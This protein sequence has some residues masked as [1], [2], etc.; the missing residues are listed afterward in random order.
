VTVFLTYRCN[1]DCPYRKTITR[2]AEDLRAFPQK[3]V[4]YDYDSFRELLLRLG[5]APIRHLHF[6]GG[7]AAL[8]RDLP[9]MVRLAKERGVSWVSMTSN[10]T[11]PPQAV[12][13]LDRERDG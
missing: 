4:T 6:T 7:E 9:R 3:G 5:E 11:L 2:T 10:G 13:L 1:L 12:S 8:V